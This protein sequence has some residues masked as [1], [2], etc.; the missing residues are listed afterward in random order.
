MLKIPNQPLTNQQNK[1]N[2]KPYKH[3]QP[4]NSTTVNSTH[5]NKNKPSILN[6]KI[7]KHM[8]NYRTQKLQLQTTTTQAANRY[9]R[10]ILNNTNQNTQKHTKS[11]QPTRHLT[12]Q[13][14]KLQT[15]K[16]KVNQQSTQIK[17]QQL[18]L[19]NKNKHPALHA[20]NIKNNKDEI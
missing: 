14:S 18:S 16:T 15:T 9:N 2:N 5:N 1:T 19:T 3:N 8:A 12:W 11:K 7:P 4:V 6:N 10:T 17:M 20:A 13:W